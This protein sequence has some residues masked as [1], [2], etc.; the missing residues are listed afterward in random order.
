AIQMFDQDDDEYQ[1]QEEYNRCVEDEEQK[2][3][4]GGGLWNEQDYYGEQG[5]INELNGGADDEQG[6]PNGFA[7]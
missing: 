5:K 4:Q 1:I 7:E 3:Q 6:L 2:Q